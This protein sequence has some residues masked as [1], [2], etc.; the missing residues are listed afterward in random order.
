MSQ[1]AHSQSIFPVS[2]DIMRSDW[3]TAGGWFTYHISYAAWGFAAPQLVNLWRPFWFV[4]ASVCVSVQ[5][6]GAVCGP[7]A[8]ELRSDVILL[9]FFVIV[10]LPS[11]ILFVPRT[12][13]VQVRSTHGPPRPTPKPRFWL[14]RLHFI[15][16]VLLET[17]RA[18][19]KRTHLRFALT[20]LDMLGSVSVQGISN[21]IFLAM[22]DEEISERLE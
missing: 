15:L 11:L 22:P 14:I 1:A 21:C 12:K 4:S 20:K 6:S 5:S 10:F 3:S 2:I 16:V 17:V 8:H 7:A 18:R 9:Y 13:Q 19:L